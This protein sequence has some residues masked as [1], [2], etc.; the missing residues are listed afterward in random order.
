MG[1][2]RTRPAEHTGVL[3]Q[4]W[5]HRGFPVQHGM[6]PV[7][8]TRGHMPSVLPP[9][10]SP[11]PWIKHIVGSQRNVSPKP[12]FCCIPGLLSSSFKSPPKQDCGWYSQQDGI[13]EKLEHCFVKYS[14]ESNPTWSRW[15]DTWSTT[16]NYKATYI[17]PPEPAQMGRKLEGELTSSRQSGLW[18]ICYKLQIWISHHIRIKDDTWYGR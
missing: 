3:Q 16:S 8:C 13:I 18:C 1:R 12:L 17:S 4:L 7:G 6:T 10:P 14:W 15:A 5:G 9:L 11:P 2:S